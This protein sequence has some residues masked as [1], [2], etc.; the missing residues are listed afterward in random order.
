[1]FSPLA[2]VLMALIGV[3][4]FSALLVLGAYAP[5]LQSGDDGQAHALSKSAVG[6]A[7]VIEALRLSREPAVIN[8]GSLKATQ[9]EGLLILTPTPTTDLKSIEALAFGGPVLVVPPKWS[10]APDV[11]HRGWVRKFAPIPPDEVA[12]PSLMARL[13]L[14]QRGQ[15]AA[16]LLKAAGAPFAPGALWQAGRIDAFQTIGAP[17]WVPVL[18]DE[19]GAAVL[20]KDARKPIYV[21]SD[22]DLLN[23]QGIADIHTLG[24]AL[25]ILRALRAGDGPF[26]FD[27]RLNG[28]GKERSVLRLLFD[29]PFLA[30]TLCLA[31]AAA[32]A[33]FQAFVRFGPP[34][35]GGR[36]IPLGKTALVDNTAALIRLAGREHRMG[37]RYVDLTA[38]L[39]A[40]AVGAPR[41]LGGEALMVFLDRLGARRQA[42]EAFSELSVR[43][44][45]A[46]TSEAATS[47]AR[48]LFQWRL[49]LTGEAPP[50]PAGVPEGGLTGAGE[51]GSVDRLSPTHEAR[52]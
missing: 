13:S 7:G 45:V 40:R 12:A 10:V 46:Q 51:A 2:A 31:V 29:P 43:A 25:D 4:A 42:P 33:G 36:V 38:D 17:G 6:F 1:V 16:P 48:R 34:R 15:L 3:F 24:A 19:T 8:R 28:F 23:T 39:A 41:G 30:V 14:R 47:A 49:A 37:A 9:T 27:V 22:P 35:R 26:I 44:R 21:L 18:T 50:A 5:D 11:T 20:V 32:L 52:A